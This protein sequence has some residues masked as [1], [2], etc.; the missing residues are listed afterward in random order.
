MNIFKFER[1]D[2]IKIEKHLEDFS[3]NLE[4]LRNNIQKF[5]LSLL[6]L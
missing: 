3:I 5:A 2:G 1:F 4:E 6:N